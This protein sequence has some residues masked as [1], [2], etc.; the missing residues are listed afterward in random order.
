M[1][2]EYIEEDVQRIR[3]FLSCRWKNRGIFG[4]IKTFNNGVSEKKNQ[5]SCPDRETMKVASD[6]LWQFEM[7]HR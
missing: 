1:K 2:N 7:S 5:W 3:G 6:K 4:F